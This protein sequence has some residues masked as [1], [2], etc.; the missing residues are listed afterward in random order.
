VLAALS[1]FSLASSVVF[2]L[3]RVQQDVDLC[4]TTRL[5]TVTSRLEWYAA[6]SSRAIHAEPLFLRLGSQNQ[7]A[8]E[9][10]THTGGG[11][12]QSRSRVAPPGGR[13]LPSAR[14]STP[15]SGTT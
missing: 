15:T 13:K 1:C 4:P 8:I 11:H 14:S 9:G 6:C 12:F 10:N 2:L 3:A 7:L 5:H